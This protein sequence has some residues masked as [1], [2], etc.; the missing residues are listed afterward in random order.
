MIQI[1]FFAGEPFPIFYASLK[2][3][4]G[5]PIDYTLEKLQQLETKMNEKQHVNFYGLSLHYLDTELKMRISLC[6]SRYT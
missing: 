1:N 2:M 3:K 4:E 5:T 6:V